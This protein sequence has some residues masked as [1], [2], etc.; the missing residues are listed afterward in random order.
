MILSTNQTVQQFFGEANWQGLKLVP[1]QTPLVEEVF[2]I[3]FHLGLTVN[4]YFS[5][6]NWRGIPLTTSKNVNELE[7]EASQVYSTA[8]LLKM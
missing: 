1:N 2:S 8:S 7:N 3:D 4:E 5:L 6:G